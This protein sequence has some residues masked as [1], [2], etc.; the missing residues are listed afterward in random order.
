[1]L[2]H[3]Y[4]ATTIARMFRNFASA[5]AY[6]ETF[7]PLPTVVHKTM[8]LERIRI[9][10]KLLG[11]PQNKYP[12]IH[13]GGT[14]GKGSTATFTA[15]ILS[16]LG[17]KTGLHLSP[18]LESLTERMQINN[19]PISEKTFDQVLDEVDKDINTTNIA[20]QFGSPTYFELLVAMSFLYFAHEKVQAAV[21]EVGLG[22]TLDGTN[23][24]PASGVILTNVSLDHTAILGKTVAKICK[25]KIGI[26][27]KGAPFVVSGITQPLLRKMLAKRCKDLKVPLLLH[28]QNFKVRQELLALPG[29]FQHINFTLAVEATTRFIHNF[30]PKKEK[31]LKTAIRVAAQTAFIPGRFEIVNL[32]P[33]TILD[34]AHNRAKMQAL[35]SSVKHLYSKQ[36]FVS[37]VA[38]KGDKSVK[39]MLREL[40]QISDHYVF[41]RFTQMIDVGKNLALDPQQLAQYTRKPTAII[42]DPISAV[43]TAKR[44]SFEKQLPLLVTGSLYLVGEVRKLWKAK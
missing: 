31:E 43:E 15:A 7:I 29:D 11:D 32:H 42:A 5:R 3:I 10:C 25:D 16:Q 2:N 44:L 6:L 13:V 37:I 18:H 12:I 34:G 4:K 35:V 9:L 24:I 39:S 38:V 19:C 41:T 21:I 26:I 14:S 23:I 20:Q 22:G 27:K 8:Q 36:K 33:L 1:M 28:G 30:F 17:I 40:D